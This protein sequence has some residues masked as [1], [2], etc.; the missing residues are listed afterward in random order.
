M[1]ITQSVKNSKDVSTLCWSNI[2]CFSIHAISPSPIINVSNATESKLGEIF[3]SSES[4]LLDFSSKSSGFNHDSDFLDLKTTSGDIYTSSHVRKDL[5]MEQTLNSNSTLMAVSET[6]FESLSGS[7]TGNYVLKYNQEQWPLFV[8]PNTTFFYSQLFPNYAINTE[9][10]FEP[11]RLPS[12]YS[13]CSIC[14]CKYTPYTASTF[15]DFTLDVDYALNS[16]S[17][18]S[19]TNSISIRENVIVEDTLSFSESII[20]DFSQKSLSSRKLPPLPKSPK[21]GGYS[22]RYK[23]AKHNKTSFNSNVSSR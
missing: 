10:I 18:N 7:E 4:I 1:S 15:L 17:Q 14:S 11:Y 5:E 20:Q 8:S 19:E 3:T 16:Q 23:N 12:L 6:V 9:T 2:F 22:E 13:V 21:R